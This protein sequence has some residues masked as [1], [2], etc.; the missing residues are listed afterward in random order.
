MQLTRENDTLFRLTRFG[1]INCFLLREDDGFT[2]ID[3]GLAGSAKQILGIA[4]QLDNPISRIALT[5]GHI[6][7]AGSIDELSKDLSNADFVVGEREARML[8]GDFSLNKGESG[9]RL[10]GFARAQTLPSQEMKHGDRIGS[11]KVIGTPGHTPGHLSFLDMRE[12]ALI[13]GDAFAT[14]RG[15]VAAGVFKWHFPFSAIFSWNR[16]M[17]AESARSLRMLNATLLAVGHG[18]SLRS[19]CAEMDRAIELAYRQCDKML[20]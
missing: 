5:H 18:E 19:P 10:L 2:L 1:M 20:K 14:Q 8:R 16:S 13:A 4:E 15:L 9:K 17:A 11:L 7:H 6:D 3:T 12:G